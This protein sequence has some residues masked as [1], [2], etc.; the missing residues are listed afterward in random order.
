V[1]EH[2]RRRESPAEIAGFERRRVL[3]AGDSALS[4]YS[5]EA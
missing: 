2:S 5:P 4:F 1:L 3:P